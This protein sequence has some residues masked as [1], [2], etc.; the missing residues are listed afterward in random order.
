VASARGEDARRKPAAPPRG[1]ARAKPA[2]MLSLPSET[3]YL[4]LV[5]ELTKRMAEV[6]GFAEPLAERLAL[7]VDEA[8]T[9]VIEHA[10]KG[11]SDPRS[12]CATRTAGR[13]SAWR[14]STPARWW[15][16][17]RCRASTWTAS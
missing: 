11:A 9:N 6:A 8:T 16:R 2:L 5:R 17:A 3:A 10:Y 7:A 15:T 12:S 1:R 14:S 13:T 4:G